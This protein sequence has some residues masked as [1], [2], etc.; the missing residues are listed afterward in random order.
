MKASS[1][2]FVAAVICAIIGMVMGLQMAISGEHLQKPAHAH[3]NLLGWVSLFLYGVYYR[4]NPDL[5]T[6]KLAIWQARVA[7]GS[8]LVMTIGLW[9]LYAGAEAAEPLAAVGSL[10]AFAALLVFARIVIGKE[11][12]KR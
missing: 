2:C 11:R 1:F 10:A 9:F 5:D 3:V 12:V 6:T 8:V 7:L 4:L